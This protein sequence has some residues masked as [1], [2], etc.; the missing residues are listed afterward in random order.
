MVDQFAPATYVG[1]PRR[2]DLPVRGKVY[3]AHMSTTTPNIDEVV[4]ALADAFVTMTEPE[5]RL[6]AAGYRLLGDGAPV[7]PEALARTANLPPADVEAMLRS[8]PGVY[9]D[10]DGKLIGL[11]GVAVEEVSPHRARFAGRAEVSLW[12]ALDPL[13]IAPVLGESAAIRSRCPTTGEPI[14]LT[15]AEGKVAVVEPASTAVS[16]VL[17]EGPFDAEVRQGFCHFVHFFASPDAADAWA[18]AHPGTFWVPAADAAEI[19]W[20][21]AAAAFPELLSR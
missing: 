19:G 2:V 21:L 6:I 10:G 4:D 8:S 17:P 13:F 16:F 5:Q 20:R 9:I 11:W 18:D 1:R 7:E 15:I 14:D 12:C 3:G